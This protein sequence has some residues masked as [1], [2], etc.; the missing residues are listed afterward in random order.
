MLAGIFVPM[1]SVQAAVTFSSDSYVSNYTDH[2]NSSVN[3]SD[4][5]SADAGEQIS[6]LISYNN[7]SNEIAH[8]TKVKI[9]LP[10]SASSSF[11]LQAKV[12][13]N[14][15]SSA[16]ITNVNV[17]LSSSQT[18]GYV[19]G[20]T[21]WYPNRNNLSYIATLPNGQ[22]GSEVTINSGST[23]GLYLGDLEP[24]AKGYVVFR[25]LVGGTTGGGTNGSAPSVTTNSASSINTNSATLNASVNPNG[26]NTT[27]WFQYGTDSTLNS[28][29]GTVGNQTIGNGTSSTNVSSYLGGLNQNT[30]Y[31]FRI[32][33]Q[34]S[35]GSPAYGTVMSFTT[36]NTTTQTGSAPTATT[37]AASTINYNNAY[38]NGAVNPNGNSTNVWFEYGTNANS[39]GYSAGNQ[40]I[41]SG[42][43][44]VNMPTT[45]ISGL[46]AN[47]TYYF[48]AVAQNSYGVNRGALMSFT[49]LQ[50]TVNNTPPVVT[51]VIATSITNNS[52]LLNGT[53]NPN[54]TSTN[55]WFEYGTNPNSLSYSANN[56]SVGNG[57]SAVSIYATLSGL[58]PNTTYYYRAGAQS[59]YGTVYGAVM[60][61]TT[62]NTNQ[63][64][65]YTGNAPIVTTLPAAFIYIGSAQLKGTIIPNNSATEAWFEWGTTSSLGNAATRVSIGYGNTSVG[66]ETILTALNSQTT[67]YYRAV[68]QNSAGIS[69]GAIMTLTTQVN[70]VSNSS[71][72]VSSSTANSTTVTV[73]TLVTLTSSFDNTSPKAGDE[74]IYTVKYKNGSTKA[75]T[76]S[77]LRVILPDELEYKNVD[78]AAVTFEGNNILRFEVG[79]INPGEEGVLNVHLTV[80]SDFEADKEIKA[81]SS[82]A[83]VNGKANTITSESTLKV[84]GGF[85]L[86]ASIID[87]MGTIFGTWYIDMILAIAAAAG[88]FFFFKGRKTVSII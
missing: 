81:S 16:V 8:G 86:A 18:L 75:V 33:A 69:Y 15:M 52:A 36:T 82:L 1:T 17:S 73:N 28:V 42:T 2:P 83:Y 50:N 76:N 58:S 67:Y 44:L 30:T 78:S 12:A 27:V 57:T 9:E 65:N 20:S 37:Y 7:T 51:T 46:N 55:G 21:K 66:I 79:K 6:F 70:T 59:S 77:T 64:V 63:V 88:A 40:N 71:P 80:K 29:I 43:S 11:N 45:Y 41:G 32:V 61:F 13:A 62:T 10:T 49:T 85:K 68:A 60:S 4:S 3:W 39:L 14:G 48:Q 34:N 35:Y 38:L 23:N 47:T 53:V 25:A 54:G 24:G 26:S 19:S 56:Q 22:N 74:V 31:Y 72:V 87:I 5:V 84:S